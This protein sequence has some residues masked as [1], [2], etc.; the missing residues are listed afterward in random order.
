MQTRAIRGERKP[1]TDAAEER[2]HRR[3]R[4]LGQG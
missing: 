2:Y 3:E 1:P 4:V